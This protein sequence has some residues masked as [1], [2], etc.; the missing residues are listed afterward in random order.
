VYLTDQFTESL[1][2][3]EVEE[4]LSPQ[5]KPH[6]KTLPTDALAEFVGTYYSDELDATAILKM[7]NDKLSMKLGRHESSAEAISIDS[8]I[9]TYLNDDAYSLGTRRIDFKRDEKR[10]VAGFVMQA[11]DIRHLRFEKIR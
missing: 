7:K 6:I 2:N 9:T 8:F 5:I 11:E 3:V 4:D 10:N 1:E